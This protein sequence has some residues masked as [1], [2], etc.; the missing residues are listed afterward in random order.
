M[1]R[2]CLQRAWVVLMSALIA[3]CSPCVSEAAFLPDQAV[4]L[5]PLL[6]WSPIPLPAQLPSHTGG[7]G[8]LMCEAGVCILT[9]FGGKL[10]GR[11]PR[12]MPPP[13]PRRSRRARSTRST[14]TARWLL[15]GGY[16]TA[17][18]V[19]TAVYRHSQHE[20]LARRPTE[21]SPSRPPAGASYA[22]NKEHGFL[23]IPEGNLRRPHGC[24]A[25]SLRLSPLP[26]HLIYKSQ[27][28]A[29][30]PASASCS[31]RLCTQPPSS[32]A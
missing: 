5:H 25:P 10:R 23:Q 28:G 2:R 13:R 26:A 3:M 9:A 19:H 15:H 22:R 18:R 21:E 16:H 27:A 29:H 12:A 7:L 4:H 24:L 20:H 32:D 30:P 17:A 8:V 31:R 14:A 11:T 1:G 6:S